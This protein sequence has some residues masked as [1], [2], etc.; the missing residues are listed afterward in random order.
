MG[1]ARLLRTRSRS[2]C[3]NDRKLSNGIFLA[4]DAKLSAYFD[5]FAA[6]R[7]FRRL[8]GLMDFGC[9]IAILNLILDMAYMA[10][11]TV[12]CEKQEGGKQT[13][14]FSKAWPC[15]LLML[16]AKARF[17]KDPRL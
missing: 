1:F 16:I 15:A 17:T 9:G 7:F 10:T 8:A 3:V 13:P 6:G 11:H 2:D 5:W 12:P 14:T 4:F